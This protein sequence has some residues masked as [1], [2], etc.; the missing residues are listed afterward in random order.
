MNSFRHHPD[1]IIYINDI[2]LPVEEFLIIYPE[3]TLP[4]GAIGQEYIQGVSH[5]I[6]DGSN[7]KY[8]KKSWEDGDQYIMQIDKFKEQIRKYE[9]QKETHQKLLDKKMIDTNLT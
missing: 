3:Y 6:F 5:R 4:K 8:L 9:N 7:E 1:G 2:S